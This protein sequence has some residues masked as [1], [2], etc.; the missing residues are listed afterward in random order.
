[1]T[2]AGIT[3]G[4]DTIHLA[5]LGFVI[6]YGY[7][8]LYLQLQ[9]AV[10]LPTLVQLMSQAGPVVTAGLLFTGAEV[11]VVAVIG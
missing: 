5:W 11:V 3:P 7:R 4:G 2:D 8:G 9:S 6:C 1:M 10:S